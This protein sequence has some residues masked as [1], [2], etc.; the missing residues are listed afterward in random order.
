[1]QMRLLIPCLSNQSVT[2]SDKRNAMRP[3]DCIVRL[4]SA[5]W[6]LAQM[7]MQDSSYRL[8]LPSRSHDIQYTHS[9]CLLL[10]LL[11][12]LVCFNTMAVKLDTAA[13][14]SKNQYVIVIL[15]ASE[16]FRGFRRFLFV[17]WCIFYNNRITQYS[18]LEWTYHNHWVQFLREWPIW[19]SNPWPWCY[20]HCALL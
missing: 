5:L 15:T 6:Y 4:T 19:R 16:M 10:P 2:F 8:L 11:L 9:N 20:Q 12:V 13:M 18:V 17:S 14:V 1:M 3:Q 7:R